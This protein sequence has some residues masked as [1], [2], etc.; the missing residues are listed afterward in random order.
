[1]LDQMQENKWEHMWEAGRAKRNCL[2]RQQ[3]AVNIKVWV[4]VN[5]H[6]EQGETLVLS[7]FAGGF[8]VL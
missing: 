5:L 2:L 7:L 3:P 8:L 1:M 6:P 4:L